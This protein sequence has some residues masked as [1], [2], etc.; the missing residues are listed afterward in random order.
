MTS[1]TKTDPFQMLV[2]TLKFEKCALEE[3]LLSR[4]HR[5]QGKSKQSPHHPKIG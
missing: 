3:N 2:N 1:V 4:S 5:A